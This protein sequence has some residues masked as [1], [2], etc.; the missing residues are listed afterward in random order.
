MVAEDYMALERRITTQLIEYWVQLKGENE[1]PLSKNINSSDLP[2][3]WESC[4]QVSL[5]N[6]AESQEYS[7]SFF[8]KDIEKAYGC[9]LSD[10]GSAEL[11]STVASKLDAQFKGVLS[12]RMPMEIEGEFINANGKK[13]AFRQCLLPFS[14]DGMNGSCIFGGMRYKIYD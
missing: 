2:D 10:D 7:Y 11:V 8:G 14:P 3:I 9:D 4:F 6:I 13:V 1:L 12:S 5:D